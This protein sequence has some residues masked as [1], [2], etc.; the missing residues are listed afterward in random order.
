MV[1]VTAETGDIDCVMANDQEAVIKTR[2]IEDQRE[3]REG[4]HD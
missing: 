2:F 1:T 4:L 3:R